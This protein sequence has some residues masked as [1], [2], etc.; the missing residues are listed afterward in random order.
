MLVSVLVDRYQRVYAR[1]LYVHEEP[2]DFDEPADET[3]NDQLEVQVEETTVPMVIPTITIERCPSLASSTEQPLDD[4]Q[5]QLYFILGYV[6]DE[7]AEVTDE[8]F[9]QIQTILLAKDSMGLE[10]H[11]HRIATGLSTAERNAVKF[12]IASTAS[13]L[14]DDEFE[15]IEVIEEVDNDPFT[16]IAKGCRH[17]SNVLKT[18][19]RRPS[20]PTQ[21]VDEQ[22]G[23][24]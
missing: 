12:E 1:K 5:D 2:I 15:E 9:Q 6:T 24:F 7:R 8:C 10:F 11:F 13:E 16:E 17:P 22:E 21:P 20:G 19:Y 3:T 4:D 23:Y 14:F 18:F